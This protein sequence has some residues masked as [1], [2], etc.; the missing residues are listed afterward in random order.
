MI[1]SPAACSSHALPAAF[2]RSMAAV[3][4]GNGRQGIA[5]VFDDF[6]FFSSQFYAPQFRC[7][8]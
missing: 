8:V 2:V 5:S 3:D 7:A 1:R 4:L 6:L